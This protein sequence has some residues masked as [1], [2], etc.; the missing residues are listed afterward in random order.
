MDIQLYNTYYIIAMPQIGIALAI[1]FGMFS[2]I[3]WGCMKMGLVLLNQL[4]HLHFLFS[5]TMVI[6]L[7]LVSNVPASTGNLYLFGS[8]SLLLLLAAQ[9]LFLSNLAI[10][11]FRK[12]ALS[13]RS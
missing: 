9:V 4:S 11:F 10:G 12:R 1:V 8:I 2:L 5:F 13:K 3:Y 6:V 7:I